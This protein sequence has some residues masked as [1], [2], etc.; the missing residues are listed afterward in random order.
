MAGLAAEEEEVRRAEASICSAPKPLS[1]PLVCRIS[2]IPTRYCCCYRRLR[3]VLGRP[4]APRSWL[5]K[6]EAVWRGAIFTSLPTAA[7]AHG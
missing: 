4:A 7:I 5:H 2:P 6:R 1:L 3:F